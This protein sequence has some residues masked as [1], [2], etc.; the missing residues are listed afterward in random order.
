MM[1]AGPALRALID[2]ATL[3]RQPRAAA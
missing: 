3:K 1:E 2:E